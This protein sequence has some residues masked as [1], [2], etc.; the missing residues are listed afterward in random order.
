MIFI[1]VCNKYKVI[2]HRKVMHQVFRLENP[3]G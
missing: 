2:P 3:V 1:T